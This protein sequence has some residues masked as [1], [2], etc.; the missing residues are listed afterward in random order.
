[1]SSLL[2][3]LH[4]K[5]SRAEP[6]P[7]GEPAS[8]GTTQTVE[9]RLAVD[10]G[11]VEPAI[12]LAPE[13]AEAQAPGPA[14]S[15]PFATFAG[16]A[17]AGMAGADATRVL[18]ARHLQQ[19]SRRS[20]VLLGIGLAAI[21][22][23]AGLATWLLDET[24]G[25]TSGDESLFTAPPPGAVNSPDPGAGLVERPAPAPVAS[26]STA[27]PAER[28]AGRPAVARR[29]PQPAE[30]VQEDTDW[31]DTPAI[32]DSAAVA[33]QQAA[34]PVRITR[35]TT[36][37]P[38]FPKLSEAWTAF[39]AA[40]FARA[41]ALY[42]E[43][44][45]ADPGNVDALLGLG[46]LAARGNRT[47]EA[48]ELYEAVLLAEPRNASAISAMS[49]L[50]AAGSRNLDEST[51][52]SLLREQ[53]GAANLHF[54]LG[55]QY[56]AQGRWPDAQTAFF[57]AVRNEPVNADY[58]YNLAVSLDQLGQSGPAA[59]YYQRAIELATVS[60]LFNAGAAAERLAILRTVAP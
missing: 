56:V 21:V 35:G 54:A 52:K 10:N 15:D 31:F 34:E 32:E 39:Q 47:D 26:D 45:A 48:R 41:E 19:R 3:I 8:D 28:A 27:G 43:V 24:G 12:A 42:R 37:N 57:E 9:L 40:D 33:T 55:L 4:R 30:P 13:S 1:M 36:T 18:V 49:T 58:A 25:L 50:P 14:A 20:T 29:K 44:R 23:G 46:A 2:D 17:A 60:S 22:V 59:A 16:P 11:P 53:P 5:D 7:A 38:L 6:D 51:L